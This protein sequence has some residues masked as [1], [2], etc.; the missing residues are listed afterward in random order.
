MTVVMTMAGTMGVGHADALTTT[1]TTMAFGL[2]S[3]FT[4][5]AGCST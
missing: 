5:L 1:T 2:F 4:T 3:F